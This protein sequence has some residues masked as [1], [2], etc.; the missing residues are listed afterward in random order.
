MGILISLFTKEKAVPHIPKNKTYNKVAYKAR[1][2]T[3]VL[4][5]LF[6][7]QRRDSHKPVQ[8]LSVLEKC[9]EE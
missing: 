6:V 2:L 8:T 9:Y 4:D 7:A 1:D 5:S 3:D